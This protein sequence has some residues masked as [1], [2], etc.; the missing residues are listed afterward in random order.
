MIT[1]VE[2][3]QFIK[4]AEKLMSLKEKADL[5]NHVALAP[6]RGVLITGT[7][8]V[9]KLRI[10][11]EGQGKSGSFRVVYYYYNPNNPVLLF[12]VFGK[13]EKANISAAEKSTLYK[14]VQAIKKEMKP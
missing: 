11:R 6:E 12:T 9:R 5:I 7:G 3:A 10:A 8:G 4:K 1:I 13:N 14:L 2:T